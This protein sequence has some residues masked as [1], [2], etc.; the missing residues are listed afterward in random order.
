MLA[1]CDADP[2]LTIANFSRDH[3]YGDPAPPLSQPSISGL[4]PIAA[5]AR[6]WHHA[7]LGHS[8][9]RIPCTALRVVARIPLTL[10]N[11]MWLSLVFKSI[12]RNSDRQFQADVLDTSLTAL[13]RTCA[14]LLPVNQG[15]APPA[16]AN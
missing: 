6:S 15:P 8:V 1:R 2:L 16:S 12:Y 5:L 10:L 13:L 14:E 3:Y 11:K 4:E 9:V 7:Q